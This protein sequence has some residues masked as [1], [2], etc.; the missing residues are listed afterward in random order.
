[1]VLGEVFSQVEF[2]GLPEKIELTLFDSVFDPPVAYVM[3]KD[4]KPFWRILEF[5][6]PWVVLF[7]MADF[8]ENC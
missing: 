5:R 6:M 3:P 8:F 7:W 2:T 4:F 1:M